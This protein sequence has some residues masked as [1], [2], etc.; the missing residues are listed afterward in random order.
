MADQS[1]I[2]N[3]DGIYTNTIDSGS[4]ITDEFIDPPSPEK[5]ARIQGTS[6]PKGGKSTQDYFNNL[7]VSPVPI[8]QNS[9]D[10]A[11]GFLLSKGF[12]KYSAEPV[13]KQLLAVTYYSKKPIWY[14]LKELDLLP[15]ATDINVKI[16]QILNL[17]N[18]GTSYI[19]I[20]SSKP[21]NPYVSRLLIK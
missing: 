11:M 6:L 16:L 5:S 4:K 19:G 12:T 15:D 10:A 7:G 9:Y 1:L 21:A 18:N 2:Q 17:N 8:D 14:W 20:R 3:P 13:V